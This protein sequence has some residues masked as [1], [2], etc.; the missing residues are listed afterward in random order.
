MRTIISLILAFYVTLTYSQVIDW[1]NFDNKLIDSLVLK[2]ANNYRK[3]HSNTELTHSS[4]LY[5]RISVRQTRL[6]RERQRAFHPPM[7][8][9]FNQIEDS[10]IVETENNNPG[11]V[12]RNKRF[13]MTE[14]CLRT[15]K[16]DNKFT[17]YQELATYLI[18]LWKSSAAHNNFLLNWATKYES[19]YGIGAVS[20]QIGDFYWGGG[21]F[22]GIYASFQIGMTY[23][24][25]IN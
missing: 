16:Q 12:S 19:T 24:I 14:I 10:L 7:E 13:L 3:S 4:L 1:N 20:V 6:Q 23:L 9:L 8:T 18:K 2:E 17:T 11:K 22:I 25:L 21:T 15:H 5:E